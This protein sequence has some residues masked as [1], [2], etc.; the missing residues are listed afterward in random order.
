MEYIIINNSI[1]I[2]GD[3]NFTKEPFFSLIPDTY[4]IQIGDGRE[5][6][7][8]RTDLFVEPFKY[9]GVFI[10]KADSGTCKYYAFQVPFNM[11][12][13]NSEPYY[14]LYETTG[15]EILRRTKSYNRFFCPV[16]K[17][18]GINHKN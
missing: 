9:V 16:F 3:V 2:R 7:S 13:V 4:I 5:N 10:G 8:F 6:G 1:G 15:L 12:P 14:L 11:L 17:K 18:V